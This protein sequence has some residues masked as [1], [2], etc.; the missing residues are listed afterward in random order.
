MTVDRVVID[1]VV[2]TA[3]TKNEQEITAG[4]TV[5]PAWVVGAL[6]KKELAMTA[7]VVVVP[8]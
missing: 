4:V 7:G 3:L 2:V 8:A 6:T 1:T 5:D